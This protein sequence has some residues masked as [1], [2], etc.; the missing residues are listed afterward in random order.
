MHLNAFGKIAEECWCVIPK[1]FLNVELGAYMVMPNYVH[2]III[3]HDD[4]CRGTIYRAPTTEKFQKPVI[5]SI[6]TIIRTFK[7]CS[8]AQYRT[9]EHLATQLLRTRD[10][11]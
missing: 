1:H 3:I 8:H 11:G 5:G 10:L 4:K 7:G 9:K 6:P 2:G